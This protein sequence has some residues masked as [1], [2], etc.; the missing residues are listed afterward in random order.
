[1]LH[2]VDMSKGLFMAIPGRCVHALQK[3]GCEVIVA[4]THLSLYQDKQLAESCAG[5]HVILGGSAHELSS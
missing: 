1:M 2:S 3:R 5:I 4:L